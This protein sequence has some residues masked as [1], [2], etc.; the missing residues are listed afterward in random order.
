[1]LKNEAQLELRI[2]ELIDKQVKK[3]KEI[4]MCKIAIIPGITDETTPAAW[5]LIKELSEEMTNMDDDGFGYAALDK[6]G[7]LFGERWFNPKEAFKLRTKIAMKEGQIESMFKGFVK[8]VK[9]S[10]GERYNNFGEVHEKSL[11]TAILHARKATCAKTMENLHPFVKGDTALIHNGV[12]QNTKELT[13]E[14]GT[15]DSECILHEYIAAGVATDLK[16]VQK[17]VDKLDGYFAIAILSTMP[18]GRKVVDILRDSAA[19]LRGYY[20]KELNQVIFGTTGHTELY[21]PIPSACKDIGYTI[22]EEYEIPDC[23]AVR[24]DAMTAEVLQTV[25]FEKTYKSKKSLTVVNDDVNKSFSR[26]FGPGQRRHDDKVKNFSDKQKEEE[27]ERMLTE[28]D[29]QGEWAGYDVVTYE[30]GVKKETKMPPIPNH[31]IPSASEI[32]SK[33]RDVWEQDF[34]VDEM[35]TWHKKV[36]SNR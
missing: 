14:I 10:K 19:R 35:G 28:G 3:F 22:T 34:E 27:L 32:D 31:L 30:D 21:G 16:N 1:M 7:K 13:N 36:A 18:D 33:R 26:M 6:D 12:I 8:T 29:M 17:M 5:K 9:G 2:Q 24:L 25:D 20:I 4:D 15:C 23:K 11:R